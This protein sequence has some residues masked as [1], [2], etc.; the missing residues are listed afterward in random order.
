MNKRTLWIGLALLVLPAAAQAPADTAGGR[1]PVGF[2]Q[3]SWG[4]AVS[5]TLPARLALLHLTDLLGRLPG[6][7][8]YA[9]RLLGWPEGWSPDGLPPHLVGLRLDGHPFNDPVTGRPAYELL[10]LFFLSPVRMGAAVDQAPLTVFTELRPYGVPRPLTELRYRTGGDGLQSIMALHVQNRRQS[11]RGRPG[12]LQLLFGYG[13]HAM[14]GAYPGS[15]LRR[16]RQVLVRLRYQQHDWA[17]TLINLHNRSRVGAHG[18][19]LPHPGQAFE[20][21]Y[22]PFGAAVRYPSA[23][24]Q[25]I[26]NDLAVTLRVRTGLTRAPLTVSAYWTAQTF[27]YRNPELDTVAAHTDRYGFYLEQTLAGIIW[28]LEGVWD[29]LRQPQATA[30][31]ARWTRARMRLLAADT[32]WQRTWYLAWNGQVFRQEKRIGAEA[33]LALGRAKGRWRPLLQM[34]LHHPEPPWVFRTGWGELLQPCVA[35][36]GGRVVR[37]KLGVQHA[38]GSFRGRVEG[39]MMRLEEVPDLYAVGRGDTVQVQALKAGLVHGGVTVGFEWRRA[40]RRGPYA[41]VQATTFRTFNA[42]ASSLHR[43]Q[44]A[45][46]PALLLH[47][48]LGG[49]LLLFQEL[50]TDLY[51]LGRYWTSFRSRLLHA[52][53]GLLA[54][55]ER[56]ARRF[57]PAGTLDLYVEAGL[58]T[59]KLFLVWENIISGTVLQPGVLLV[60]IY[61]LPARRLRFGV[62]WPIW[63]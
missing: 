7:F 55:P 25:T 46:L 21:I 19:V 41:R 60:P 43:R 1:P 3:I 50:D 47:V 14:Q 28:R 13:G 15:R 32:L 9:F 62:Y 63:D 24:R 44:A 18:G 58:R 38:V 26:R 34:G 53:T 36:S 33:T 59:A 45:A 12:L 17:L 10:P 4:T 40:A 5:D 20:T 11:L 30:T 48:R 39:F 29:W 35:C 54:L 8:T 52:A 57:G 31:D 2:R 6:T 16:G 42:A 27:R 56:G 49:R 22:E 51:L 61:P 37:I 23:R